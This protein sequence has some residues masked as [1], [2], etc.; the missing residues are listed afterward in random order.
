[1]SNSL[2][3]TKEH[4]EERILKI[5]RVSKVTKGGKTLNF[6]VIIVIGNQN[7]KVGVGIG[8]AKDVAF[9]IKKAKRHG[10]Q[11]MIK[12]NL[13]KYKSIP[14]N[15]SGNFGACQVLLKPSRDGSGVV[16]GGA[17]RTILEVA[18]IKNII[19]KQLGSN[20]ILNNSRATMLAL[21]NFSHQSK[22]QKH[23]LQFE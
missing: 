10:Q 20:N 19:A 7:G 17:V 6:R 4:L 14:H 9:A 16:A 2:K 21:I 18:G 5:N 1:M 15:T 3:N 23:Y 22:E 8:K 11:N 12:I 13:T